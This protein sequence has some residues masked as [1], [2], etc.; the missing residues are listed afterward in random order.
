MK[1]VKFE[2]VLDFDF[3]LNECSDL[4][5]NEKLF[6]FQPILVMDYLVFLTQF[7]QEIKLLILKEPAKTNL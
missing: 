4:L 3:V 6:V 7:G 2:E 1:L 5:E